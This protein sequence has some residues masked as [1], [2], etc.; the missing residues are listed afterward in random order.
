MHIFEGPDPVSPQRKAEFERFQREKP[1]LFRSAATS[2]GVWEWCP[3]KGC[4]R[5]QACHGADARLC[6]RRV[7]Q[8]VLSEEERTILHL[9]MFLRA[10]GASADD[11]LSAALAHFEARAEYDVHRAG[12]VVETPP[13][14]VPPATKFRPEPIMPVAEDDAARAARVRRVRALPKR[15]LTPRPIS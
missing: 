7:I 12:A 4:R 5:S 14:E 11:A 6:I 3:R 15:G 8:D 10:R 1:A 13:A 9:A 2:M